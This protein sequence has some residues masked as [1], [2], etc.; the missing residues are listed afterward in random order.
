M[1]EDRKLIKNSTN[2]ET[3]I[4]SA[5]L[6]ISKSGIGWA[7]VNDIAG[8]DAWVS[9]HG[10]VIRFSKR[11]SLQLAVAPAVSAIPKV[12]ESLKDIGATNNWRVEVEGFLDVVSY[13]GD[14]KTTIY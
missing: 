7:E 11:F 9:F 13:K 8:E 2:T 12:G 14:I 3:I 4:T 6:S 1:N 5:G 10:R